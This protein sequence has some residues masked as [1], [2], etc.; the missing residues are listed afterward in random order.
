MNKEDLI[1][2]INSMLKDILEDEKTELTEVVIKTKKGT[3]R[4]TIELY[5]VQDN[6]YN[7]INKSNQ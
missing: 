6:K 3:K 2:M 4:D 1:Y 5:K 7:K